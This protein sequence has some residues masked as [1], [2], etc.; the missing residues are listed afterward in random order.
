MTLIT[1]PCFIVALL[2]CSASYTQ[3]TDIPLSEILSEADGEKPLIPNETPDVHSDN[4]QESEATI[5]NIDWPYSTDSVIGSIE[6]NTED[7]QKRLL[8]SI[9]LGDIEA[10]ELAL[11]NGAHVNQPDEHGNLPIHLAV[12]FGNLIIIRTLIAA[13]ADMYA[14]I[15]C[16]L[17]AKELEQTEHISPKDQPLHLVLRKKY[18]SIAALRKKYSSLARKLIEQGADIHSSD[19]EGFLPIQLAAINGDEEIVDLLIQRG[20]TIN[21]NHQ[22]SVPDVATDSKERRRQ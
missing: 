10:V 11:Q 22:T 4:A 19:S 9:T 12:Y 16:G 13:G 15:I 18:N 6:S 17:N 3:I 1:T 5:F 14:A 20:A 8:S 21:T 7:L 2:L